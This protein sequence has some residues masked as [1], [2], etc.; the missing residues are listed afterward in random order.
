[1]KDLNE[2]FTALYSARKLDRDQGVNQLKE[3]LNY[4]KPSD[5]LSIEELLLKP[6]SNPEGDWE[7]KHGSLLGIKALITQLKQSECDEE[8]EKF[9]Q[10]VYQLSLELL[11]DSEVRI[12]L[13]AGLLLIFE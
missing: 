7:P 8:T 12:R 13:A 5:I 3:Y 6:L 10:T 9:L 4:S 11:T 2:V 1:M